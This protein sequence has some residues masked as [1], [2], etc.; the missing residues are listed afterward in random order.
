[1]SA[2]SIVITGAVQGVFFR[3]ETKRMADALRITGWVRNCDDGSVEIYAEGSD[4]ALKKFV[5]WCKRGPR[6]ARIKEIIVK[7]AKEDNL[8]FF[9]ILP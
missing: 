5:E 3:A 8:R 9:A 1:M 6:N 4:G 7:D 2:H